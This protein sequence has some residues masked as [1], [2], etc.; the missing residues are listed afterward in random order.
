MNSLCDVH[1]DDYDDEGGFGGYGG[2]GGDGGADGF[3]HCP[4][5]S[6]R[7]S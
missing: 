4:S 5:S 3:I 6:S 7:S 2:G 1:R